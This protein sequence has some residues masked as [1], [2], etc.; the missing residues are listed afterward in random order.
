RL[1]RLANRWIWP[2]VLGVLAGAARLPGGAI[3]LASGYVVALLTAGDRPR[4]AAAGAAVLASMALGGDG[5]RWVEQALI[6]LQAAFLAALLPER[7]PGALENGQAA[8]LG[9]PALDRRNRRASGPSPGGTGDGAGPKIALGHLPFL[10][11]AGTVLLRVGML[12]VARASV[13]AMAW[14]TGESLLELG[15]A[16]ALMPAVYLHRRRPERL[17]PA[18]LAGLVL[19]LAGLAWV[20]GPLAAG[21][22]HPGHSLVF[23]GILWL[24]WGGGVGLAAPAGAG[25][26]LLTAAA[27]GGV[28]M[29]GVCAL[30]GLGAGLGRTW[31]K[32]GAAGGL[33][34][35][36]LALTFLGLRAPDLE[37]HPIA[38]P[39]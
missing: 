23:A 5:L 29:V 7:P 28:E 6:L 16:L 1:A 19:A 17:A 33:L 2:A 11:L 18:Q 22:I 21:G 4:A 34:A 15:A 9:A 24:A 26:G 3:P 38:A 35:S 12:Y 37:P 25:L 20:L 10:V 39:I 27:G 8:G 36:Q 32:G 30:A 14:A 13:E 31:G